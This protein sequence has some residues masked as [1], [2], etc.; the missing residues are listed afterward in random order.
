MDIEIGQRIGKLTVLAKTKKKKGPW[1]EA[2]ALW[3]TPF[4]AR[5][6]LIRDAKMFFSRTNHNNPLTLD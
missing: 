3:E 6:D 5:R 4:S 1:N 2:R